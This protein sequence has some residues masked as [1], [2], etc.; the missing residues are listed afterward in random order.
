MAK[1]VVTSAGAARRPRADLRRLAAP[2]GEVMA[3]R[4]VKRRGKG[5]DGVVDDDAAPV[6]VDEAKLPT[7]A[8]LVAAVLLLL[9]AT[10]GV[11]FSLSTRSLNGDRPLEVRGLDVDAE[12]VSSEDVGRMGDMASDGCRTSRT[13]AGE[14]CRSATR[15][16]VCCS[17]SLR[18]VIG[19]SVGGDYR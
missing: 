8:C 4:A 6:E 13:M 3:S 1:L 11:L 5:M 12:D 7:R 16:R 10:L 15:A 14:C 9:V 17:S 18:G 2:P 19:C